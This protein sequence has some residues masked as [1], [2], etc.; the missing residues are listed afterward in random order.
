MQV[1]VRGTNVEGALRTFRKKVS[2]TG[3]LFQYR[4][5]MHYEKPTTKRQRKKAAAKNRERKRQSSTDTTKYF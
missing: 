5:K 1:K 4:E 2:E 3:V